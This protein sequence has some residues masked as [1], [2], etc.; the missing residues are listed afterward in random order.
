MK[1]SLL[2]PCIVCFLTGMLL[3]RRGI[4]KTETVHFTEGETIR[5]TIMQFIP[6]TVYLTGELRYKY[7]YRADT[8]YRDVPVVDREGTIA[9]TIKDWNRVREYEKVLFDNENGKMALHLSVQYNELQRL[10]SAFTPVRKEITSSGKKVFIPFV[11]VS[12]IRF[13]SFGVGGG[14]FYHDLGIRVEWMEGGMNWG[15]MYKF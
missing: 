6:D 10:T 3:G 4:G 12:C 9:E 7:V 8:V 2:V 11:S 5:D 15:M 13:D 14:F 1:K